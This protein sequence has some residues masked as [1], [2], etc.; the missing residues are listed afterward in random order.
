MLSRG[1]MILL[2]N[3]TW[4][5]EGLSEIRDLPLGCYTNIH[6]FILLLN[7]SHVGLSSQWF[8]VPK[9]CSFVFCT[10][11][12]FQNPNKYSYGLILSWC[13]KAFLP[14]GC[15]SAKVKS[16]HCPKILWYRYVMR[17]SKRVQTEKGNKKKQWN[18]FC[19]DDPVVWLLSI[20]F[21]LFH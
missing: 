3:C 8:Q 19:K 7:T 9:I 10:F 6:L 16:R 5:P 12:P 4:A 14:W 18:A 13:L 20:F 1:E 21:F 2:F 15:A 17:D 11:W